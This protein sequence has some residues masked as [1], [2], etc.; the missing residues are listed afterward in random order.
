MANAFAKGFGVK[1]DGKKS[2][3]FAEAAYLQGHPMA[4]RILANIYEFG[5]AGVVADKNRA[6]FWSREA[7]KRGF[8][9]QLTTKDS[10]RKFYKHLDAIDPFALKVIE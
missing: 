4:S 2:V 1:A 3:E 8:G 9:I 10:L 6:T 5:H 7:M